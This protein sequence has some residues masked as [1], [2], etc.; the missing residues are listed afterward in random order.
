MKTWLR[1]VFLFVS[2]L[3]PKF[4]DE[5]TKSAKVEFFK[6]ERMVYAFHKKLHT[7]CNESTSSLKGGV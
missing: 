2:F 6:Y 7:L 5:K 3:V 1:Q 4:Q